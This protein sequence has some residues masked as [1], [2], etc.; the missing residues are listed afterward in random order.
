VEET[1]KDCWGEKSSKNWTSVTSTGKG[2]YWAGMF[3]AEGES[4]SEGRR[5]K[6]QEGEP[7][8]WTYL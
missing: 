1:G 5:A 3:R 8:G 4:K 6:E 7:P 2:E